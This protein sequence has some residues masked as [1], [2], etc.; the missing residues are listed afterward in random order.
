MVRRMAVQP[1]RTPLLHYFYES[2]RIRFRIFM[3]GG[4]I[5][6]CTMN[7]I[8][9]GVRGLSFTLLILAAIGHAE[10]NAS[11]VEPGLHVSGLGRLGRDLVGREN[12]EAASSIGDAH[13]K[14]LLRPPTV[15]G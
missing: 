15:S 7:N 14:R 1:M 12:G 10:L 11:F 2:P 9:L 3:N 8:F 4:L 6:T 13:L 5:L